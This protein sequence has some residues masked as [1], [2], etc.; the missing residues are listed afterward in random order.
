MKHQLIPTPAD[1][2]SAGLWRDMNDLTDYVHYP[3][4]QNGYS[5]RTNRY[6]AVRILG[7]YP[8]E[9]TDGPDFD[10]LPWNFFDNNL[11]FILPA[12]ILT[13]A[14]VLEIAETEPC[15]CKGRVINCDIKPCKDCD[16]EGVVY[17]SSC[18]GIEYENDC[19]R[20]NGNGGSNGRIYYGGQHLWCLACL[21]TGISF[22]P[23]PV[24]PLDKNRTVWLNPQLLYMLCRAYGWI[25]IFHRTIGVSGPVPFVFPGNG[26]GFIMPKKDPEEM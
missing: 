3:I 16:G 21:G 14:G 2:L 10:C 5:H 8:V 4:M 19:R 17:W 23:N 26:Q 1:W 11:N 25:R 9:Y 22:G 12:S 18:S 7:Q 15:E 20:C 6:I 24:L 13:P